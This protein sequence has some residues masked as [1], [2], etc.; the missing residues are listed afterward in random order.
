MRKRLRYHLTGNAYG[1]TL[2]CLLGYELQL[3]G[4]KKNPSAAKRMTFGPGVAQL[5]D[6]MQANALISWMECPE[7]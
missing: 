2:G 4:S 5:S 7:P 1:S 3:I 6:W